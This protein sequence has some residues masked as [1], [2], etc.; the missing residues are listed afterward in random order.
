MDG[1]SGLKIVRVNLETGQ[2]RDFYKNNVG[3]KIE[4]G[5]I[6]PVAAIFNPNADQLYVIDFGLMGPRDKSAGTGSVWRIVRGN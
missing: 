2:I 4:S 3:L 1:R 6:R 5:P